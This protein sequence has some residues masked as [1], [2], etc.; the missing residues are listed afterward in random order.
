LALPLKRIAG[1]KKPARD[2]REAA[3]QNWFRGVR[4]N[5]LTA[6]AFC[7]DRK[8]LNPVVLRVRYLEA[9]FTIKHKAVR[10][11]ETARASPRLEIDGATEELARTGE[12]LD[13]VIGR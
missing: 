4:W 13:A 9:A 2:L 1:F 6:F 8:L 5:E 10:G 12:S 7:I 3:M 11:M